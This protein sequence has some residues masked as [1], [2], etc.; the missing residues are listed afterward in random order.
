VLGIEPSKG[1]ILLWAQGYVAYA[2]LFLAASMAGGVDHP[3]VGDPV[4]MAIRALGLTALLFAL[5]FPRRGE[6]SA[7]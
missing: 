5:A 6:T 1:S 2:A 4:V 7:V 3:R